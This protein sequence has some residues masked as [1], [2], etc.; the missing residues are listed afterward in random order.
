L[1][2]SRHLGITSDRPLR[3][4]PLA[5]ALPSRSDGAGDSF[6]AKKG[7]FPSIWIISVSSRISP[8]HPRIHVKLAQLPEY[9]ASPAHR[10]RRHHWH[11]LIRKFTQLPEYAAPPAHRARRHH[12]RTLKRKLTQLPKHA[13][14]PAHR[15]CR[16]HV[17][18]AIIGAFPYVNLLN[19]PLPPDRGRRHHWR[20]LIRKFTQLPEY[21]APPARRARR[22]HW[23]TL[24]HKF[25]RSP[26]YAALPPTVLAAISGVC[27][28]CAPSRFPSSLHT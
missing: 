9:A 16:H 3:S 20:S 26:E 2:Y 25:T 24:I 4:S 22:H 8:A 23:H 6:G 21:A 15:A 27:P 19:Y 18:A 7:H 28:Y 5:A 12:R 11:T 14:P 13:A 1:R 10:G 17:H